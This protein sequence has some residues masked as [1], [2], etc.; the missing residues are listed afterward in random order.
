MN[1]SSTNPAVGTQ[2]IAEERILVLDFGSQYTQL[3]ARRI[4]ETGVYCEV[5]S[6]VWSKHL[7]KI[8]A[9]GNPQRSLCALL[10]RRTKPLTQITQLM[11]EAV[12]NCD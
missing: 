12:N 10:K 1:S 3:I 8:K 9:F 2:R 5:R 4:R 6:A 7:E 11:Q